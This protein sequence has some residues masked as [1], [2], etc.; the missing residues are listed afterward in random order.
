MNPF[1]KI[2]TSK[3]TPIAFKC[4]LANLSHWIFNLAKLD[5]IQN[6][7]LTPIAFKCKLANLSHWIFNLA[8]LDIE[9]PKFQLCSAGIKQSSLGLLN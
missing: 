7:K 8:K 4:K 6:S 9:K 3:L 1:Y 5:K 2:Q